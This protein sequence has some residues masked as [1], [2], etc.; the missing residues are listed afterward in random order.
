M[1][2][3]DTLLQCKVLT[4]ILFWEFE[5]RYLLLVECHAPC[6]SYIVLCLTL[7]QSLIIICL[8]FYQRTQYVLILIGIIISSEGGRERE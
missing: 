2:Y 3:Y 1:T 6:H 4:A 8:Q 7:L 5:V